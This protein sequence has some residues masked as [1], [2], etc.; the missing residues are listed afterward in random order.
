MRIKRAI[1]VVMV[2]LKTLGGYCVCENAS[3]DKEVKTFVYCETV[4][5]RF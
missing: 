2:S 4:T 1:V 3:K 5:K